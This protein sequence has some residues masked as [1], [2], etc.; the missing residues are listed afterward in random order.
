MVGAFGES[1]YDDDNEGEGGEYD[2][3]NN[4]DDDEG[5]GDWLAKSS[6]GVRSPAPACGDCA[7]RWPRACP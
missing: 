1:D 7:W 4:K 6:R 5:R 2:N 3:D